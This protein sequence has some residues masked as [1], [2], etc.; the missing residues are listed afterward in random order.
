MVLTTSLPKQD[1]PKDFV[2]KKPC[3]RHYHSRNGSE[4][5]RSAIRAGDGCSRLDLG[6]SGRNDVQSFGENSTTSE[7]IRLSSSSSEVASNDALV[8]DRLVE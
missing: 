7:G 2:P 6:D 5:L 8:D 3:E 4:S 1:P